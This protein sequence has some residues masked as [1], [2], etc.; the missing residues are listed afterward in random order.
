MLV[1]V[2]ESLTTGAVF[3][4]T[5]LI[6]T[7]PRQVNLSANHWMVLFVGGIWWI[8]MQDL[9]TRNDVYQL[10]PHLIGLDGLVLFILAP[11]FFL[12]V[13][14]FVT[15]DRKWRKVDFLHF[16]PVTLLFVL[17]LPGL[18]LPGPLKF[19]QYNVESESDASSLRLP[20]RRPVMQSGD[21]PLCF[22][23]DKKI[24]IS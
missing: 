20:Y 9:L 3:L 6:L 19:E 5:F 23:F 4:L 15:P 18:F 17:M 12:A 8:M 2:L 10:L 1:P 22:D 11:S 16:I 7:N 24:C 14:Y 21:N 13:S